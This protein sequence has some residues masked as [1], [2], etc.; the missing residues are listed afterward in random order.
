MKSILE[1]LEVLAKNAIICH[2]KALNVG[3]LVNFN[4]QKVQKCTQIK[5]QILQM[6]KYG[7]FRTSIILKT[8]FTQNL[9]DT[10]ISMLWY[11]VLNDCI[12]DIFKDLLDENGDHSESE[13]H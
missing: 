13:W 11:L 9:S 7:R 5:I 12:K 3:V 4:L 6:C 8:D 2:F 1:N 10:E